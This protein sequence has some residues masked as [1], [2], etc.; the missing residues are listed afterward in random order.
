MYDENLA[1]KILAHALKEY[2]SA[3][4]GMPHLQELLGNE[5]EEE[6][7]LIRESNSP[8]AIFYSVSF[9]VF[10]PLPLIRRPEPVQNGTLAALG[11]AS[12][13]QCRMFLLNVSLK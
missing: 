7:L 5:R 13:S 8:K 9:P 1:S 6:I 10:H 4:I 12:R 2:P 11:R 3:V